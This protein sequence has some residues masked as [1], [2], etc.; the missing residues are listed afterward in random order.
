MASLASQKNS[1]FPV[2]TARDVRLTGPGWA[3]TPTVGDSLLDGVDLASFGPASYAGGNQWSVFAAAEIQPWA[4]TVLRAHDSAV[5]VAGRLGA[6][7]A[8]W[9]GL[10]LPYHVDAF[11][12][13]PESAFLAGVL[14]VDSSND[15][16]STPRYTATFV[17]AGQRRVDVTSGARGV[18]LKEQDAPDWQATVDG[19]RTPI[20]AAGPGMMWIP[21]P[22]A[23]ASHV[24]DVRYRLSGVERLGYLVSAVALMVL[25]VLFLVPA[26]WR[27]GTLA[28]GSGWFFGAIEK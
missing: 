24:V 2:A 1:P 25:L 12:S 8:I 19:R 11:T 6:G 22:D 3:W 28:I 27:R 23:G 13:A 26:L 16:T 5:L 14:G 17:D 10:G 4:H 15:L 21:L 7:Q 20:Y 18:L 9:S